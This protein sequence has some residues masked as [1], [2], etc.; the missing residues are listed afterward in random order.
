M[1]DISAMSFDVA[2]K[3][4][5]GAL[6][7]LQGATSN[8]D[9]GGYFGG[10]YSGVAGGFKTPHMMTRPFDAFGKFYQPLNIISFRQL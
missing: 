7:L 4:D 10:G 2:A 5:M 6:T 8:G 9:R 1:A 3:M